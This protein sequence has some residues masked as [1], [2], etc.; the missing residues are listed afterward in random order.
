MV[1]SNDIDRTSKLPTRK[2]PWLVLLSVFLIIGSL[3]GTQILAPLSLLRNPFHSSTYFDIESLPYTGLRETKKSSNEDAEKLLIDSLV[4]LQELLIKISDGDSSGTRSRKNTK[5]HVA[6]GLMSDISNF[7]SGGASSG[8]LGAAS[9]GSN[10]T[11]PAGGLAS[12]FSDIIGK[13]GF[14]NLT[15]SLSTGAADASK[16]LG[17]GLGNGT[18]TGLDLPPN[19]TK[20][21][22]V[23]QEKPTGI[24][25]IASNLGQGLS[26][27]LVGSINLNSVGPDPSSFG[28][29]A[30]AVGE[31]VGN[32]AA[33]GLDLKPASSV[34]YS[35]DTGIP[36]IAGNFAQGLTSSF[37]SSIDLKSIM[38]MGNVS[39]DQVKTAAKAL[40][41]G[42]G[43]GAAYATKLSPNPPSNLTFDQDGISG[44]AGNFGQ[45]LS[46]SFLKDINFKEL[47]AS[48]TPTLT[49]EKIADAAKGFGAGLAGGAVIGVGLQTD[50][51]AS[52]IPFAPGSPG[53]ISESFARG[54][55]ESFLANGTVLRVLATMQPTGG[56]LDVGS[57]AKGLAIGLVDGVTTSFDNAGG[58]KNIF[59]LDPGST[60]QVTALTKPTS[61]NDSVGGAATGFGN[62]LGLQTTTFVLQV[63]GKPPLN[64]ASS[65]SG[66]KALGAPGS[67][68]PS[69]GTPA[70]GQP[71]SGTPGNAQLPTPGLRRRQTATTNPANPSDQSNFSILDLLNIPQF[72]GTI[73]PVVQ[74]SL[75]T[76]KCQ[77]VGGLASVL[78]SV[79]SSQGVSTS[80]ADMN[81]LKNKISQLGFAKQTINLKDKEGG[82]L[83]DIN[84]AEFQIMVNGNSLK[85]QIIVL[86]LHILPAITIFGTIIPIILIIGSIRNFAV[87][88]GRT[89][90]LKSSRKIQWILALS[91]VLPL[92]FL[93]F[94]TGIIAQGVK[95]HFTS[96]HGILGIIL[97][98]IVLPAFPLAYFAAKG[99]IVMIS[100]FIDLASLVLCATQIISLQNFIIL[101]ISLAAHIFPAVTLLTLEVFMKKW[102]G[103][104]NNSDRRSNLYL[105]NGSSVAAEEGLGEKPS[106]MP[107][108]NRI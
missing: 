74:K 10:A 106:T 32:G 60:P 73:T 94:V 6:R 58:V 77:G 27:S 69:S 59:N 51:T 44:V 104:A 100:G 5:K 29:A 55:S 3:I 49:P 76:L 31:G 12:G 67:G 86:V 61:Y 105:S 35:N 68:Q 33:A 37:L 82:N 26:S 25:L 80:S 14:G 81:E 99:L 84:I 47:I 108:M 20:V 56:Q 19:L 54:L 97:F 87:M 21:S 1:K 34:V 65:N 89:E 2:A 41:Q 92:T 46:V 43:S 102:R 50:A 93:I 71:S 88:S 85:K 90:V 98:I 101:G 4:L 107:M 42:L 18:I 13:I 38:S 53:Q 8:G 22:K 62:G 36:A 91:Q 17:I 9:A 45:G 57:V 15:N 39:N 95:T 23:L 30:K 75:D 72:N 28:L 16:Y 11:A 66:T 83:Y 40:A 7:F 70:N 52:S 79:G 78:Y 48:N 96:A 24:N 103:S 64:Q 63:L